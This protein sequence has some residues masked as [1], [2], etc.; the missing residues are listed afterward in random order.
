MHQGNDTFLDKKNQIE[1]SLAR[2]IL[3]QLEKKAI[4]F[5]KAQEIAGFINLYVDDI[6]N[7][8]QLT[9]FLRDL[10]LQWNMFETVYQFY[11][12]HEGDKKH[13]SNSG[14]QM[15]GGF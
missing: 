6:R 13:L 12:I 9:S 7:P 10:S 14:K 2:T 8:S 15:G 1:L 5:E 11:N 3:T 4:S